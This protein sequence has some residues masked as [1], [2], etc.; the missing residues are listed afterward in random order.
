TN[1][2][3]RKIAELVVE[4]RQRCSRISPR[5]TLIEIN[6]TREWISSQGRRFREREQATESSAEDRMT[7]REDWLPRLRQAKE[8]L[9]QAIDHVHPPDSPRRMAGGT[10]Q[11]LVTLH[12]EQACVLG[13]EQVCLL[14]LAQPSPTGPLLAEINACLAAADRAW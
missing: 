8:G 4:L 10:L 12:T 2:F 11:M 6:A 3:Y 1:Q 9:E 14:Q 13:T 5:L 7:I